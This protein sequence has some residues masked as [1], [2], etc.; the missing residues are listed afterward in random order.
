MNKYKNELIV[1]S[2]LVILLFSILYKNNS[3][4]N[5]E[6]G[7][8]NAKKET[9][10]IKEA[11]ILRDRWGSK[12]ISLK[13]DKMKNPVQQSKITWVKKRNKLSTKYKGLSIK[14]VNKVLTS[15]LNSPI[16]IKTLR[17]IRKNS[18]YNID[19]EGKW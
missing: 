15:I 8:L 2:L 11:K 14:E 5:I 16:Q 10:Q 13:I 9:A 17:V 7:Y 1:F 6:E 4:R 12:K 19:L 3:Y 18:I